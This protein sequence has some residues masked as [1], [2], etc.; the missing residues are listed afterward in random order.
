MI[1]SGDRDA[2]NNLRE[3]NP[4]AAIVYPI[5]AVA[6]ITLLVWGL[7]Q[8]RQSRTL[9]LGLILLLIAGLVYDTTLTSIGR[10]F[11]EGT[12]LQTLNLPRFIFHV[13]V[14]PGLLLVGLEM[15]RRTG[16]VWAGKKWVTAV[17]RLITL[18]L[19]IVGFVLEIVGLELV[20]QLYGGT[21]RYVDAAPKPPVASIV[22]VLFLLVVSFL[23]LRK[24]GW[25]WLFVGTMVMFLG[26]AVPQ[27]QVGPI[28]ASGAEIIFL[29]SLLA[30]QQWLAGQL[31]AYHPT[32]ASVR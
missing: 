7:R 31:P 8:W 12:L 6:H 10:F 19:I 14:T 29:A 25:K 20:P 26:G 17:S 1:K 18:L 23:I 22:A 11:G 15:A 30:T 9:A 21:L 16:F 4:M 2:V 13:L 27:S 28:V 32:P 3:V 5:Y 24:T